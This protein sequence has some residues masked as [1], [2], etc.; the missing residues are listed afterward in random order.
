MKVNI[1]GIIY[2]SKEI[3]ILIE[4]SQSDKDN[5]AMMHFDK[6]KYICYPDYL[7]WESA[8]EILKIDDNAN[9]L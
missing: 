4:L 2:D 6:F 1:N 8:K 5:I 7:G 3:P 9:P